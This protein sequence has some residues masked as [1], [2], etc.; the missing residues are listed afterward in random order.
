MI[1]FLQ[2]VKHKYTA[3]GATIGPNLQV[4]FES[5]NIS[6]ELPSRE[7]ILNGGWKIIPLIP[8]EVMTH[9]CEHYQTDYMFTVSLQITKE[10]VDSFKIG[11]DISSC[12]LTAM[13][14]TRN[15]PSQLIHE[16][17]LKGTKKPS[18]FSVIL[19]CVSIPPCRGE[20]IDIHYS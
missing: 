2:F 20:S 16:I 5:N 18:F 19:E 17:P 7:L 15:E 10:D 8:P 4:E 14:T 11:R 13:W 3:E 1:V 9:F 6:L 12:Q